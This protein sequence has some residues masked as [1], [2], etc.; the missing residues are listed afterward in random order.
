[1]KFKVGQYLID[2]TKGFRYKI[3]DTD[4]LLISERYRLCEISSGNNEWWTASLAEY[5]L[6]AYDNELTGT[7]DVFD[8]KPANKRDYRV[9]EHCQI[10]GEFKETPDSYGYF[11]KQHGELKELK[12]E[13]AGSSGQVLADDDDDDGA[14]KWMD[15]TYG[16][17]DPWYI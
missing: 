4:V 1:M 16:Y 6:E 12:Q 17:D 5:I 14:S 2:R 10:K 3:V 15:A 11:C 9:C 7:K 13:L 8:T